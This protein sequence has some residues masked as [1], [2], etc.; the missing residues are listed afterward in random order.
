VKR[1]LKHT[2]AAI[3]L[4][5]AATVLIATPASAIRRPTS[6]ETTSPVFDCP[7]TTGC[8]NHGN[9]PRGTL[10]RSYCTVDD[11]DLVFSEG[12]SNRFGFI[13]FSALVDEGQETR[14]FDSGISGGVVTSVDDDTPLRLC[15]S[16][17]CREL[18][19]LAFGDVLLGYCGRADSAGNSWIGIFNTNGQHAG[20]TRRTDL[21]LR[22]GSFFPEC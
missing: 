16:E 18:S 1:L 15:A 14:C 21:N 19:D 4:A 7:R 6:I 22:P 3:V 5:V 10:A 13:A 12:A 2:A 11:F 17:N 20:F 8:F 9:A